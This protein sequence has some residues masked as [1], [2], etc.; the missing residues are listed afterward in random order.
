MFTTL[1]KEYL[2]LYYVKWFGKVMPLGPLPKKK[3]KEHARFGFVIPEKFS[4]VPL[5]TS[6]L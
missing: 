3:E 2:F 5:K 4:V 1:F 6:G